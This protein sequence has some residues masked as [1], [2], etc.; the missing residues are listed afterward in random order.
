MKKDD[1]ASFKHTFTGEE[2]FFQGH[3]PHNAILPGV[4]VLETLA[5]VAAVLISYSLDLKNPE[6]DVYL[7]SMNNVK[8]RKPI[9]PNQEVEFFV[10]LLRR[11]EN[12]CKFYGKALLDDAIAGEGEFLAMLEF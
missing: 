3:F 11:K 7:M 9:R 2:W 4:I 8:F 10:N 12:I 6:R 5:Q 1:F